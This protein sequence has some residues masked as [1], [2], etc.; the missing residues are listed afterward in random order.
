MGMNPLKFM[1]WL[2]E[3]V[4]DLIVGIGGC[5]SFEIKFNQIIVN[6]FDIRANRKSMF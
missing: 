3:D 6:T 1:R 5:C 2:A 4:N